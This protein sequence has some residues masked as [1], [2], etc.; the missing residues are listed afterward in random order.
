MQPS[1]DG[2]FRFHVTEIIGF[3]CF[4]LLPVMAWQIPGAFTITFA[5]STGLAEILDEFFSFGQLL[6]SET[7]HGTDAFQRKRQAHVSRPDHGAFP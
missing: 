7:Q 6:L 4:P 3:E 1:L 5:G 2:H